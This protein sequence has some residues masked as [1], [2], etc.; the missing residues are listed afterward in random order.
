MRVKIAA[1]R[2]HA[3]ETL[4]EELLRGEQYAAALAFGLDLVEAERGHERA[5]RQVMRAFAALGQ[6]TRAIEQYRQLEMYLAAQ[7]GVEP[8]PETAALAADIVDGLT[9]HRAATRSA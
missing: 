6:R 8:T 7:I 5:T 2:A 1:A 3:L 9:G 4:V